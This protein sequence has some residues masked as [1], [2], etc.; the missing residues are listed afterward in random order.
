[1]Y[2]ANSIMAL[3]LASRHQIRKR[4]DQQTF[5]GAL[6]WPGAISDVDTLSEQ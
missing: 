5:D 1:M 4:L 6:Q 2:D 3:N